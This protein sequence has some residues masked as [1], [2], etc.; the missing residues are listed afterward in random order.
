ME[1]SAG[2]SLS[3]CGEVNIPSLALLQLHLGWGASRLALNTSQLLAFPEI[4]CSLWGVDMWVEGPR[5]RPF[6]H[7]GLK[8]LS[9]VGPGP[10]VYLVRLP[11]GD[12]CLVGSAQI[13]I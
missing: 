7:Q 11:A 5:Q 8:Q 4:L 2:E 9:R 3:C 13:P 10:Q 12:T 1:L 6:V